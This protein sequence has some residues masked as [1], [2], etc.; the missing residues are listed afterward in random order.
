M[1]WRGYLN[2]HEGRFTDGV[3][4]DGLEIGWRRGEWMDAEW[5]MAHFCIARHRRS[6][7][8]AFV[9]GHVAPVG[10]RGLWYLRWHRQWENGYRGSMP[11]WLAAFPA[12]PRERAFTRP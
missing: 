5:E 2:D 8:A 10:L 7:N 4:Y 12:D 9:D 11:A 3:V 6:T 1:F